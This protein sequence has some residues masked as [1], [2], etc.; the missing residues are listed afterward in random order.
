MKNKPILAVVI[1]CF[2]EEQVLPETF[3]KLSKKIHEII[4]SQKI[5][6]KSFLCFVDD[7]SSDETWTLIDKFHKQDPSLTKGLK[8]TINKGHQYA[9]LAGLEV[10]Q[11]KC[12]ISISI[13]ADL[14]DDI[15]VMEGFIDCYLAGNE[16]VYGVRHK[17]EQ[18]TILKKT[19]AHLFY[20]LMLLFG[21]KIVYNHA[22]YRL[23]SSNVLAS[24]KEYK[25]VNLFLR[26]IF[27]TIGYKSTTIE[28]DR[29]KRFAG[30]SKYPFKTMLAFAIEGITSFSVTPLRMVTLIGLVSFLISSGLTIWA[31]WQ[32]I[33]HNVTPGWSSIIVSIYLLGAVQ[34]LCI[35]LIG[36]YI[37][38]IFSEVKARPRYFIEKFLL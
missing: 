14:Q 3:L 26:G 20:R 29:L 36:E 15:E 31:I 9:L 33:T 11:D 27:P 4:K 21:V 30:Q 2:N 5:S 7:G 12:D 10:V 24:L 18:D 34:L 28:Y 16:I 8:L 25:E 32:K 13:D 17:R 1:P 38:K 6:S 35:G 22:D 37:G 23:A 19:T